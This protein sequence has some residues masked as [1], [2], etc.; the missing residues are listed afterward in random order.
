MKKYF[1]VFALTI[2]AAPACSE[3]TPSE[4][5]AAYSFYEQYCSGCHGR[6]MEGG[7]AGS[8]IDN[9]WAWGSSREEIFVSIAEGNPQMGMPAYGETISDTQISQ[10]TDLIL[11]KRVPSNPQQTSRQSNDDTIKTL[12]YEIGVNDWVTDVRQP[13]H[14]EFVDQSTALVTEKTGAVRFIRDGVLQPPIQNIPPTNSEG[15]GGMMAVNVDPDYE[16]NGWI[17]LAYTHALETNKQLAMTQI[18]RG[19]V[20][21]N[22]WMNQETVWQSPDDHYTTRRHHYGTRIQF[23]PDGMLYF[24]IGDRGQQNRAQDITDPAGNIHRVHLDG[25]IP[26]DNPF[27]DNDRAIKSIYSYGHRNPQGFDFHP[28]TNDL[29]EAEHGPRGG[30]EL[31]LVQMGKNYGWPEITYGINYN[32]SVITKERVRPGLE[33]PAWVWRPSIAVCGIEFYEGNE[34]PFWRN[35]L[36]VSS[37]ANQTVRLLQIQDQR[38]IHEEIIFERRGRVRHVTQDPAGAV[39]VI[40]NGPDKIVK[41]TKI[42]ENLI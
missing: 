22:K 13:W 11:S 28:V 4:L 17:Y 39:Y 16:N 35:H 31:N 9:Q 33:Q 36:L 34:F 10:L 20:E 5:T 18:V 41:L 37:L 38:V 24:A 30:D 3:S 15:Q 6:A 21:D 7:S 1:S 12:D 32:G 23:G 19:K 42:R 40:L 2:L 25:K 8:L 27:V 26:S 14:L 29:W